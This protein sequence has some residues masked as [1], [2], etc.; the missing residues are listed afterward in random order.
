[1][2]RLPGLE[3]RTRVAMELKPSTV[4]VELGQND[5]VAKEEEEVAEEDVEEVDDQEDDHVSSR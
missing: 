2:R 5:G 1:M 3:E 4:D